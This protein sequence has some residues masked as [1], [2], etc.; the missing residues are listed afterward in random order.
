MLTRHTRHIELARVVWAFPLAR[1]TIY[2][3]HSRGQLPWIAR[4]PAGVGS[5]SRLVVDWPGA[6]DWFAGRG[7][8]LAAKAA[9]LLSPEVCRLVGVENH[10][11]K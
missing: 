8:D 4:Q 2:E 1:K 7:V 10:P 5:R 11:T 6:C 9:A 3:Y